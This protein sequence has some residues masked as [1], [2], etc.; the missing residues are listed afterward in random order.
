MFNTEKHLHSYLHM[1]KHTYTHQHVPTDYIELSHARGVYPTHD[2]P[3]MGTA[4]VKQE[5]VADTRIIYIYSNRV[6]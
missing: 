2:T 5:E 1:H 3:R 4:R 6:V